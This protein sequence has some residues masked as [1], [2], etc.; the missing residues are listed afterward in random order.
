MFTSID[1]FLADYDE[2]MTKRRLLQS[3]LDMIADC[4]RNRACCANC[5]RVYHTNCEDF[6][7]LITARNLVRDLILELEVKTNDATICIPT[8]TE[9]SQ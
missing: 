7:S 2:L 5:T 4:V 8:S 3:L 6:Q 9:E 1:Q